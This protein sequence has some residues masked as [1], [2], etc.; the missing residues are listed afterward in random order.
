MYC[1]GCPAVTSV[2]VAGTMA[3]E[4]SGSVVELTVKVAVPVTTDPSG[5]LTWAV[6]A[7]VPALRAVASP[8]A[9]L[10]VATAFVLEPQTAA[11][12]V[13]APTVAD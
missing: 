2:C 8:V 4:T 1:T 11:L 5:F 12:I 9:G 10:M 7:V 13:A 3:S 6:M